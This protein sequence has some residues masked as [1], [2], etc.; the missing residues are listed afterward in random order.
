MAEDTEALRLQSND[1]QG[2]SL[3]STPL[4][5]TNFLSWS[6]SVKLGLRAKMKMSFISE[7]GKKSE[8]NSKEMEQWDRMDSMVT[9]WI[10]NSI[11]KDIVESFMYT[12]TSRELWIELENRFGQSNGPTEYRLKKELGALTQGSSSVSVYFSKIKKLWDELAC[13]T[14]TP[15]CT[16]GA[17]KETAEIR[18]HDQTIQFLMGLNDIYDHVR[19]QILMMEPLPAVSKAYAMIDRIEKQKEESTAQPNTSQNMTMQA[20]KKPEMQKNFQKKKNVQDKRQQIC[21]ECGKSGHL[22]EA[23]FEIHGYPK[24]YKTLMKQRKGNSHATNK[25]ATAVDVGNNVVDVKAI[26]EILRSEFHKF[27]GGLKPKTLT[28]RDEDSYDFSSMTAEL[29]SSNIEN[30]DTWILDSGTTSHLCGNDLM[31]TNERTD[32]RDVFVHLADGTRHMVIKSAD[33]RL[34]NRITFERYFIC[35]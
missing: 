18:S 1:N 2:L 12:N 23:C 4:D 27:L 26:T 35:A 9:S 28:I 16:C 11:S 7:D 29:N 30:L 20:Y 22:K 3:V 24:W 8:E 6:R 15:K 13:I 21:K 10:L 32:L 19:N 31:F 33:I 25:V 34:N 17:A 5:G 14:Y